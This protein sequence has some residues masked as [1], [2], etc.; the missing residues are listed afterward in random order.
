MR[1]GKV[2]RRHLHHHSGRSAALRAAIDRTCRHMWFYEPFLSR[3]Y[4]VE[5]RVRL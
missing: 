5:S 2:K 3:K 1:I 4:F